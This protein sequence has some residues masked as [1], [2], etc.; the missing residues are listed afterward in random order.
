MHNAKPHSQNALGD[1]SLL[2]VSVLLRAA[3]AEG[4]DIH[5]LTRQ[6]RLNAPELASEVDPI[7]WTA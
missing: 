6:F 4:A 1:I 3:Q 5:R 2:H 7:S